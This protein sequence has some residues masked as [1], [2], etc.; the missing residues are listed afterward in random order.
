MPATRVGVGTRPLVAAL[1]GASVGRLEGEVAIVTGSTSGL[2]RATASLFAAEGA[3]VVVTGRSAERGEAVAGEISGDGGTAVFVAADLASEDACRELVEAA[4]ERFGRLTVLV[5]NAVAPE[6]IARDR[7]VVD[8]DVETMQRMLHVNLI[9]P[10]LMCKYAIPEM[11]RAGHGS[12]VN[13]GAT[14]GALGTGGLTAYSMSKGGLAALSRTITADYGA[15]GVRCNTVQSGYILHDGRE[16]DPSPER[17]EELRHRQVTRLA[18]AADIAEA[19]VFLASRASEVITGVILPV[20]GGAS[21]VR[22][23]RW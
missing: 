8:L 16:P 14:S 6:A 3:A 20:D 19:I 5:N 7:P 4:I 11:I 12:I 9:G 23:R 1:S 22:P 18:A 13:I 15:Q 17:L 2:G 21:A 10:A